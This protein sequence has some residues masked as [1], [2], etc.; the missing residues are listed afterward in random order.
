MQNKTSSN[1]FG[2]VIQKGD[3]RF[4]EFDGYLYPS[5]HNVMD[6]DKEKQEAINYFW[7]MSILRKLMEVELGF[8]IPFK[9]FNDEFLGNYQEAYEIC[10][11]KALEVM[12]EE[13]EYSKKLIWSRSLSVSLTRQI[14]H[15]FSLSK[16]SHISRSSDELQQWRSR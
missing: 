7:R 15:S 8:E 9:D 12:A 4:Y 16:L 3:S 5:I 13:L 1:E 6:S 2:A 11:P 10:N 14:F